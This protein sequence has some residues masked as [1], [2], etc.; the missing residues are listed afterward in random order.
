M[1]P[2]EIAKTRTILKCIV[3]SKLYGTDGPDSDIDQLGVA[4]EPVEYVAGFSEFEQYIKQNRD[5][6]TGVMITEEKIYSLRKF[7]R[8]AVGGN[9]DV[10]PLFFVPFQF[11]TVSL[12]TGRQLQELA[13]HIVSRKSGVKFLGYMESQRQRLLGERGQKKVSRPELVEKYGYDTKYAMQILRLGIQGL[14]LLTSGR[15]QLPM[16]EADREF[17]L[18]VRNGALDINDV[19]QRAGNLEHLVKAVMSESPLPEEPNTP[20]VEEWMVNTYYQSWRADR[21]MSD[22]LRLLPDNI[23]PTVQ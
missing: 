14:E 16:R 23:K 2:E 22:R 11:Q 12:A 18:N 21:F 15:I 19:L 3:G 17:L 10:T 4:V 6:E 20:L 5:P 9:P 1:T 8:L 7:L 13:P